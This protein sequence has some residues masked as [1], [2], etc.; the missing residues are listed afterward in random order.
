MA[1]SLSFDPL[2]S[3]ITHNNY[4]THPFGGGRGMGGELAPPVMPSFSQSP[5]ASFSSHFS[6]SSTASFSPAPSTP[7]LFSFD[8]DSAQQHHMSDAYNTMA[9]G[10]LQH[11]QEVGTDDHHYNPPDYNGLA[12]TSNSSQWRGAP[13]PTTPPQSQPTPTAITPIDSRLAMDPG[14]LTTRE[15]EGE[16]SDREGS[17]PLRT[18]SRASSAGSSH[19]PEEEEPMDDEDEEDDYEESEEEEEEGGPANL[20]RRGRPNSKESSSSSSS[21]VPKKRAGG[22]TKATA[23]ASATSTT[24]TSTAVTASATTDRKGRKAV[25]YVNGAKGM[26]NLPPEDFEDVI[27]R[28]PVVMNEYLDKKKIVYPELVKKHL[29]KLVNDIGRMGN[30]TAQKYVEANIVGRDFHGL[31]IFTVEHMTVVIKTLEVAFIRTRNARLQRECKASK[32]RTIETLREEK[33][34]ETQTLEQKTAEIA[35]LK[36]ENKTLKDEIRTLKKEL[37]DRIEKTQIHKDVAEKSGER[38]KELEK[39]LSMARSQRGSL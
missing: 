11:E 34:A 28:I 36:D 12:T 13:P 17:L 18:S 9:Q 37:E 25:S 27:D 21:A 3:D 10:L 31:G 6:S 7:S 20:P 39:A 8:F 22:V 26:R 33:A 32:I 4:A 2:L 15:Y 38:I 19:A 16:I 30:A 35:A 24:S 1:N 5:T 14:S 23:K 29:H